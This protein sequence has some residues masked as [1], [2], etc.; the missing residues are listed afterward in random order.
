MSATIRP[1]AVV[2]VGGE[3]GI[4]KTRLVAEMAADPQLAGRLLL[5]GVCR[6]IRE[7]FPLGP[8][9]EALRGTG[10]FGAW[11]T[12]STPSAR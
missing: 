1:P 11:P 9:V 7:P 12:C 2:V 6:R 5:T 4:G 10:C 8:V 3:A